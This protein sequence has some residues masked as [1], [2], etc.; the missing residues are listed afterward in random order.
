MKGTKTECNAIDKERWG[1]CSAASTV[2]SFPPLVLFFHLLVYIPQ[3]LGL[4]ISFRWILITAITAQYSSHVLWNHSLLSLF[5]FLILLLPSAFSVYFLL[6]CHFKQ[7]LLFRKYDPSI[8]CFR[9]EVISDLLPLCDPWGH[10]SSNG[11][12]LNIYLYFT[13]A[14][15]WLDAQEEQ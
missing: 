5:F 1:I 6:C 4:V 13:R 7:V 12:V 9:Q 3:L 15:S 11:P 8:V 2:S 14:L 10:K